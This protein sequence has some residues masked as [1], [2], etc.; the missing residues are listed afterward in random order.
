MKL[1]MFRHGNAWWVHFDELNQ[2]I[3]LPFR[4]LDRAIDDLRRRYPDAEIVGPEPLCGT[5][6]EKPNLKIM[7]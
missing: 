6:E 1:V 2:S 5:R 4:R 7:K 3:P